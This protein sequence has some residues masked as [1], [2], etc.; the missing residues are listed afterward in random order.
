MAVALLV[1]VTL[2]AAITV[3]SGG[4]WSS[5]S[6][7]SVDVIAMGGAEMKGG[8]SRMCEVDPLVLSDLHGGA[9]QV[10]NKLPFATTITG[11]VFS[12]AKGNARL[13]RVDGNPMAA[14]NSAG[15]AKVA[16]ARGAGIAAD[17]HR[18]YA[19]DG[20]TS[21]GSNDHLVFHVTPSVSASIDDIATELNVL[22][23]YSLDARSASARNIIDELYCAGAVAIV[24]N[25]DTSKRITQLRGSVSFPGTLAGE[26]TGVRI[27][28][29]DGLPLPSAKIVRSRDE[30]IITGFTS[31]APANSCRV[32]VL[33]ANALGGQPMRVEPEAGFDR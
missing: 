21:D 6:V 20:L 33:L 23:A 3:K 15:F 8:T 12:I 31:L 29:Q 24:S 32:I 22:P 17:A 30:F 9:G 19:I 1:V 18:K 28:T 25:Q 10:S 26:L 16:L 13:L 2:P 7:P 5:I 14:F 4:E 11:L 27:T